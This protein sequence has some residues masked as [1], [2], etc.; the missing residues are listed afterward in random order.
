MG[1]PHGPVTLQQVAARAGVSL[2]TASRAI[3]GSAR[4]VNPQM[5]ERVLQA[6]RELNYTVNAQAQAMVRGRSRVVGLVVG[7]IV[8]PYF[9]TIATGVMGLADQLGLLVTLAATERSP[10]RECDQMRM[11]S[12]QRAQAVVIVGSRSTDPD[13]WTDLDKRIADYQ[14][15]GG[16]VV[17][18]GQ[19]VLQCDTVAIANHGAGQEMARALMELGHTRFAVLAG[20]PDLMTARDRAEGFT[21]A[22][23][24]AGHP[25][26]VSIEGE[27]TRDGGYA[28]MSQLL[29]GDD[30]FTCV[31]AVADALAIGAMTAC[32]ERGLTIPDDL[33]VAGFDDILGLR[34]IH[35][36]LTTYRLPLER[37][38]LEALQLA[39]RTPGEQWRQVPI[40]GEV[41]IR[42]ST[43]RIN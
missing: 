43:R 5:A 16:R 30:E 33:S 22:V 10:E 4:K 9:S 40:S 36:G 34:D 23:V 41:V 21:Q 18:V 2:A 11:F 26:P 14:H 31:F 3:N 15:R 39:L 42:E 8:D 28:A 24:A 12:S 27:F 35:P 25:E 6:A 17:N 32:R 1:D 38:G 7:D 37:V 20:S 13:T 29:D 19:P